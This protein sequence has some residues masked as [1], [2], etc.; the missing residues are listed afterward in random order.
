MRCLA[1]Y[2]APEAVALATSLTRT[3][4]SS[5]TGSGRHG[6]RSYGHSLVRTYRVYAIWRRSR[7]PCP[8]PAWCELSGLARAAQGGPGASALLG[9]FYELG[10]YHVTEDLQ[11]RE[12]PG[13]RARTGW[14]AAV[15]A[16]GLLPRP[17]AR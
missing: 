2:A 8:R 10:P 17:V 7:A 12:N 14:L 9:N 5:H 11:L 1:E 3:R 15:R 13:A 4:S 16:G 6:A